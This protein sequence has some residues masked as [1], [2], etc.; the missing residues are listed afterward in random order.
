MNCYARNCE[1]K[2]WDERKIGFDE[3]CVELIS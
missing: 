3:D 2:K 1:G